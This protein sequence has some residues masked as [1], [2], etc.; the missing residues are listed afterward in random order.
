MVLDVTYRLCPGVGMPA[1]RE[2]RGG[3]YMKI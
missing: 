1:G 2:E 3:V